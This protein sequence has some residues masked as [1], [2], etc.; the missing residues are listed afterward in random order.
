MYRRMAEEVAVAGNDRLMVISYNDLVAD[1]EEA[2]WRVAEFAGFEKNAAF[3]EAVNQAVAAQ[4]EYRPKHSNLPLSA[5]GLSEKRIE[6]DLGAA[7]R[8][9]AHALA[10]MDGL[11]ANAVPVGRLSE[12]PHAPPP[13]EETSRQDGRR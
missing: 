2:V 4:R 3:E 1:L 12:P 10:A 5:F 11:K 8:T 13:R 7:K 9:I 6:A